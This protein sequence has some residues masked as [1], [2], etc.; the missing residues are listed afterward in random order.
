M[1]DSDGEAA[2]RIFV[3]RHSKT[4]VAVIGLVAEDEFPRAQNVI[5]EWRE[6]SGYEEWRESREG[7]QMALSMAGVDVR[8]ATIVLAQFLDWCRD[9]RALPGAQALE[10]FAA[11][12]YDLWP[13]RSDPHGAIGAYRH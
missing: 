12:S 6:Y 10:A 8:M 2:P 11:R 13:A 1:R 4:A 9:R 3:D 5:P 7:F